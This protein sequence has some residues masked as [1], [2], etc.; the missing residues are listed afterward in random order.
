VKTFL[1]VVLGQVASMLGSAMT[2]FALSLW[3]W[4]VT[5]R[6]TALSLTVLAGF[7]PTIFLCPIAGVLVD[8]W[9]RKLVMMLSD[10][11]AATATLVL[12]LLYLGGRLRIGHLYAANAFIGIFAAFQF[13][14]FSAAITTLVPKAQYGR[15]NGLMWLA[16]PTANVFGPIL[17]AALVGV[18]GTAGVMIVD[19]C[20]AAVAVGLLLAIRVPQ[21][22]A[23]PEGRRVGLWRD[24]T[25]GFHYI[26]RR[27]SLLG[28]QAI[29]F[30]K[31]LFSYP[32]QIALLTP[33][34]LARGGNDELLLGAVQS[35]GAAGGVVGGLVL[36]AWGGPRR[37][38]HG[39]LLGTAGLHLLGQCVLGLGRAGW[40]WM[41][42]N[43]ALFFFHPIVNGTNQAIWQAKV[44]PHIQGRVFSARRLIAQLPTSFA[45]LAIGPLADRV[46]EPAMLA[47]VTRPGWM[48]WLIG[49][50]PGAGMALMMVI[51]G[52]VG[53]T[54]GLL[55]YCVPAIHRVEDLVL[56]HD[57][58]GVGTRLGCE[59]ND[60][61]LSD[62]SHT[63]GGI[64]GVPGHGRLH[65]G[66]QR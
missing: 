32:V 5:G 48:T 12:L 41:A 27:P 59:S 19:L 38:V 36:S 26:F 29:F 53:T 40:V 23:E 20:T 33:M 7:A 14:A 6:A 54:I 51:G 3:A 62:I 61:E 49:A 58:L 37:R 2:T 30:A 42:A 50:G 47:G 22:T 31:N 64:N 56:D 44:P 35:F 63:I 11:A 10:M 66:G 18:I 21:P 16:G 34:I 17:A 4:E 24:M 52:T 46:F 15:A 28:L 39:V 9:N 60:L 55:G 25:Y 57:V 8:R 45:M 43:F 13:P 1:L 65:I